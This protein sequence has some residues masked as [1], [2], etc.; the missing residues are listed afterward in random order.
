[1][2]QLKKWLK[3]LVME[4]CCLFVELA[5]FLFKKRRPD[6][7]T[8]NLK[9]GVLFLDLGFGDLIMLSPIIQILERIFKHSDVYLITQIPQI[10]KLENI[11][12]IS[13]KEARRQK[14]DIIISPTLNLHHLPY[15]FKTEYWLGYFAKPKVQSNF[16]KNSPTYDPRFEHY[17]L[18]GVRI[19]KIL[20][21]KRGIELEKQVKAEKVSYPQLILKEP[22]IFKN[23]ENIPYLII[24]PF[25][26]SKER[27]WPFPYF[28]K[29][30][31]SLLKKGI[32]KKI[33]VIGGKSNWE[34]RYLKEFLKYFEEKSILNLVGK[35]SIEE[36]SFLIKNSFL[37]L[38]LDSGPAHLAYLLAEKA[39]AIFI[40]VD[41]STR[42]PLSGEFK[43]N[44]LYFYPKNCPNFPCYSG[45]YRPNFRRCQKCALTIKPEEVLSKIFANI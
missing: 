41:P 8:S 45:L 5:G 30:I 3:I 20:D 12:W 11:K 6:F 32:V 4:I 28:A 27:Q 40:S 10:M 18:R 36:S 24:A 29:L 23:L 33:V 38:G 2:Y 9:V 26:K 39:I 25:S 17:I 42:I 44:I 21:K 43:S 37:Y 31:K 14:F 1:M 35:I 22:K 19:I 15:I 13:Q 34:K 7:S 16:S